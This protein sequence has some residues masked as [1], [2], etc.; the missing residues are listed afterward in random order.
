ML[1][2]K[3]HDPIYA[4]YGFVR[5]ADE[6]VDTF[7]EHDKKVLLDTFKKETYQAIE[8]KISLNPVIHSFQLIV[9]KYKIP[10]RII[11]PFFRSMEMD[12]EKTVYNEKEYK[13]YIV[14]SAEVVGLMCMKVF[15]EG[16]DTLYNEL[17]NPARHLGAGLQ[18]VNFLRDLKSDFYDKG[19]M[20]FPEMKISDFN[21]ENKKRIEEDILENFKKAYPGI[22]R[23]PKGSGLGVYIAYVYYKKLFKKLQAASAEEIMDKRIRIPDYLKLWLMCT[24]LIKFK[25][26]ALFK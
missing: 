6:I 8:Q 19:R 7:H 1:A 15:C 5:F 23:L 2:R 12:L 11:E 20:Y 4:L 16:N 17:E 9:N 21:E 14:G 26:Q 3:F 22:Q 24:S 25:V 13:E 18:K 10:A